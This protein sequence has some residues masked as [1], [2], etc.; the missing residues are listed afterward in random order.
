MPDSE[1]VQKHDFGVHLTPMTFDKSKI[2]QYLRAALV[3]V[4]LV[5]LGAVI[6]S[7][8][9]II[10]KTPLRQLA[11]PSY[12]AYSGDPSASSLSKVI[13]GQTPSELADTADMSVF[14][15]TWKL[16]EDE[17]YLT[18]K[19]VPQKMVDGAVAG[20]V[21]ALGDPYTAYLPPKQ[22]ERSGEDLAGSFYGVGIELGFSEEGILS[23][24]APLDGTPAKAAGIEPNDLI[25]NVKDT[26]KQIDEQ[27]SGW[28]LEKAV[29][30]I[31]GPKDSVV[32]LTLI[33]KGGDGVP[34]DVNLTRDEIVVKS[35]TL[36]YPEINGKKVA[37]IKLSRFGERT[38]DE[39]DAAVE[40]ILKHR[41]EIGG[42]VLDMRNNPGGLF[43]SSQYIA[44]EFIQSGVI[45][46]QKGKDTSK[47][48]VTKGK[49]R[50]LGIPTVVLI[51]GG[52]ASASEIV[53]GALKD[54]IN[55][56]L[57]GEKTF[58]KG[59]VQDRL[60]LA[61]GG[62]V[63]ITIAQWLT[64][65]GTWIHEKGIE[66]DVEAKDDSETTDLDEALA[67]AVEKL[68]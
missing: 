2:S 41:A 59:T 56:T 60:E 7:R 14:W 23:V 43:D 50:L 62:G 61:N 37:H 44:S 42:I 5:V 22:N 48:F 49:H 46:S 18:D 10:A 63:H 51:N 8:Y 67:V 65:N 16:L 57:V 4:L 58:G 35:V 64:P 25:I 12:T 20:M 52:S 36:E 24:V 33:R 19:L 26:Q 38:N 54:R 55:A 11:R 45:V 27:T 47:D 29:D 28:S 68:P 6:E 32:T 3:V 13:N 1:D 9:D 31:R 53:A 15:Q 66:V 30:T 21:A 34:F 40:D 17:Y 39:W